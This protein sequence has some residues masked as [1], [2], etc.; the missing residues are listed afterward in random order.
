MIEITSDRI[1]EYLGE[2]LFSFKIFDVI[3]STNSYAKK[4]IDNNISDC[5]IIADRQTDGRGRCGRKFYSPADNGIYMS[6]VIK[7]DKIFSDIEPLTIAVAAVTHRAIEKVTGKKCEIKWVNDI[8]FDG[9]KICGILCENI[10][11]KNTAIVE[12]VIIG[13]GINLKTTEDFPEELYDIAGALSMENIDRNL[14]IA[15]ILKGIK[16]FSSLFVFDKYLSYYKE[17]SMVLGKMINFDKN[18]HKYSGKVIDINSSGNLIVELF[19]K[20]LTVLKSGEVRIAK[21]DIVDKNSL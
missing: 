14:L 16:E 12:R 1:T 19:D 18:N 8:Y 15:E 17:H 20:T 3:E 7:I 2:N 10:L 9:K 4:N 11:R 13:I 6:A 21:S 5:V